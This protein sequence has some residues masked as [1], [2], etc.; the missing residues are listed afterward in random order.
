MTQDQI[1]ELLKTTDPYRLIIAAMFAQA[2]RD[3]HS[4]STNVAS[5]ART[6]LVSDEAL[7]WAQLARL[8]I[9]PEVLA[10]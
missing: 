4:R 6:F 1:N 3:A 10:A 5:D 7:T 9:D 2:R 8:N